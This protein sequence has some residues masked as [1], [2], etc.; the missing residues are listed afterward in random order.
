MGIA[1]NPYIAFDKMSIF[2][3]LILPT[4]EHGRYFHLLISLISFFRDLKFLSYRFSIMELIPLI[5]RN[6]KEK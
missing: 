4:H 3:V 2:T 1:L 6:I 5:L